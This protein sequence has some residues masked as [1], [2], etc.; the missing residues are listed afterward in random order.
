M[1]RAFVG[2]VILLVLQQCHAQ[3]GGAFLNH[4]SQQSQSDGSRR[5]NFGSTSQP[6]PS[7][8]MNGG[9]SEGGS[10]LDNSEYKDQW[11]PT[12]RP[13]FE[14]PQTIKDM[15]DKTKG[16]RSSASSFRAKSRD[17]FTGGN[18]MGG[19]QND[20]EEEDDEDEVNADKIPTK[21]PGRDEKHRKIDQCLRKVAHFCST[22]V[23][24]E[25]FAMFNDCVYEMRFRL[26]QE[27][28]AWAEGHGSCA[29]D[30]V[31]HCPRMSPADTTECI[32]SKKQVLSHQ[33]VDSSFY[34]SMEEGFSEFRTGM[35]QGVRGNP[36]G[37]RRYSGPV[38]DSDTDSQKEDDME[39]YRAQHEPILRRRAPK[40]EDDS[41]AEL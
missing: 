8:E 35:D 17:G 15:M 14:I 3:W 29:A 23:M 9:S 28:Q 10:P 19:N 41:S 27:C 38:P 36:Q 16:S 5:P 33:C 22:R 7:A 34:K 30:M 26:S 37:P 39:H 24:N 20:A 18:M 13:G 25:N 11:M 1:S 31:K 12:G 6:H 40:V 32:R 21:S 4:N 2:L